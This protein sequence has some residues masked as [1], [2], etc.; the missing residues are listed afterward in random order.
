MDDLTRKAWRYMTEGRVVVTARHLE[1]EVQLSGLVRG[2]Q[3]Y[4]V[5]IDPEGSHC[6]CTY[7]KYNPGKAHSHT[8]AVLLQDQ[9][10]HPSDYRER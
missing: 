9:A 3:V 10:D 2:S 6:D 7:G 5:H 1:G 8:K 4:T